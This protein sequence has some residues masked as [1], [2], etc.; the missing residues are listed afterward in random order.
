MQIEVTL[1]ELKAIS[2]ALW[3]HEQGK[4]DLIDR[5]DELI[6]EQSELAEMD[7]DDCA[8]GACKL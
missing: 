6:E 4:T 5:I 2:D 3:N 1:D 8:G 7:F